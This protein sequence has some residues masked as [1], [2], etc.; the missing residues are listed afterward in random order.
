MSAEDKLLADLGTG[1]VHQAGPI[2]GAK[3][4]MR[5]PKT[6][7][8]AIARQAK[9]AA[10]KAKRATKTP[11]KSPPTTRIRAELGAGG[12][13]HVRHLMA[14]AGICMRLDTI[15]LSVTAG[16]DDKPVWIQLAK[17][18][19]FIKEGRRFD[20]NESVFSQILRNFKSTQNQRVPVD[21]EHASETDPSEG[22]I[23]VH[24]AP[25]QG[26]IRDMK[27]EGGNLYGLVYWGEQARQQIRAGQYHY[28]SPAIRFGSRDRQ[29]GQEIGAY[30]SSGA[31]TNIPFLD[32]MRPLAAKDGG[33]AGNIV[34]SA[35]TTLV[36]KSGQLAHAPAEYMP[37][38]KACLKLP[39]LCS[40]T[41]C[42]SQLDRL[43]DHLDAVGGDATASHQGV[44]LA[45]YLHPLRDL[46]M[47]APGST[48]DEVLEQIEEL[49]EAA[50]ESVQP[51]NDQDLNGP[52][53]GLTLDDGDAEMTAKLKAAAD[54]D[55]ALSVQAALL[56]LKN[57]IA[58][59]AT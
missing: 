50:M 31:L 32:G 2:G 52:G 54:A 40:A 17:P 43:R 24:G 16:E 48:W 34:F 38:L 19:S 46:V 28:F 5:T 36:L 11:K 47:A 29:T 12:S 22:Q 21:Y 8:A 42:M 27:I 7:A 20:L 58:T 57:T 51:D 18:G 14:D 53:D 4:P 25:A 35:G 26:W 3:K 9:R 23:A 45:D 49:I 59:I 44:N 6:T 56:T 33:S 10:A 1:D 39:E 37:R 15:E 30:M 13:L 55:D 41:E